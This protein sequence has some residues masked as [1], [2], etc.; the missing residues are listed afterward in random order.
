MLSSRTGTRGAPQH[1][2]YEILK[3][4]LLAWMLDA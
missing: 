2:F 3:T 1:N 4:V